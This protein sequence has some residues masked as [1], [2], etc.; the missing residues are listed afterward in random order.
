MVKKQITVNRYQIIVMAALA[1]VF[2]LYITSPAE[3]ATYNI[4]CSGDILSSLN[5]AINASSSGDIINIGPGNCSLSTKAN[6][7]HDKNIQIIGAGIGVTN[8]TAE[9]G[10]I[11]LESTGSNAPQWRIS[12]MSLSGSGSPIVTTVWAN[13]SASWRGPFRIDHMEINYPNAGPDGIIAIYGPVYGLIDH[14]IFR[15]SFEAFILTSGWA[16]G[17][18]GSI[19]SLIGGWLASQP[20]RPGAADYLYIEDNTFEGMGSSGVAALDTA[21]AGGRVVFRHNTLNNTALYAHWTSGGTVNS[22]W[23]E[24]YNNKFTW[25]KPI[26][27]P[28]M[29]LHGGGTGLI[30]NNTMVGFADYNVVQVGEGRFTEQGQSSAPLLF[31]DGTHNWDGNAGDPNAPGW[32]CLAQTGRAAGKTI[33]Q[34]QSG[35]KPGSFPLYLWNNGSQDKCYNPNASGSSCDNSFHIS[36]AGG[37]AFNYFK[38]TPHVTSGYGNGDVDYSITTSKPS[39]AGTHTLVYTP[40]QY[41]YPLTAGGMPNPSGSPSPIAG[42]I[43]LDHI[44]NS[45]DYSILNSDWFT[46]NSRSDLNHDGL[47]NAIDYSLLNANWFRTW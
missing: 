20:F 19:T 4:T 24:I 15:Q 41:P 46:S 5:S 6:M 27:V 33:A 22:L 25:T 2:S 12:G 8:I 28:T 3:A 32:P 45:I 36:I 23:W 39:G 35:D 38:S 17:E 1:I 42:D 11:D 44:V 16:G 43:N 31:C 9:N 47:V 30:Y 13:Q 14:N 26:I 34:I 40:F 18:D 21:Y 7:V 29:R 37:Y 10:L